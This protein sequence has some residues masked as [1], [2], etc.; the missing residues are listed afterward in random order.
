MSIF[1]V[2]PFA[3]LFYPDATVKENF[4]AESGAMSV[5]KVDFGKGS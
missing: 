2:S 3:A 1:F 5:P 4:T